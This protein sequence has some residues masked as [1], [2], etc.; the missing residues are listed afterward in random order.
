[1]NFNL[2][3]HTILLAVSGSRAYG[4]HNE[5]S[6]VDVKGVCI[7]PKEYFLG[8]RYRFEQADKVEHFQVFTRYLNQEQ[9]EAVAREKLEG[10]IYHLHKFINLA[11]EANPNIL[12]V[13]FCREEDILL[14]TTLGQKLRDHRDLFLSAKVK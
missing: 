6:D 5:M 13:L 12:D 7:P 10:S 4:L 11:T 9:K 2:H 1:M 14:Q 8:S 3:D